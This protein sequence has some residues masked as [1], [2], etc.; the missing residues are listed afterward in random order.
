MKSFI[1]S[2]ESVVTEAVEGL[3]STVPHLGRLDG[4]PAIKVC[5]DL[6]HDGNKTVSVIS[7]GGSGHEPAFAGYVG[8]GMLAAAVIGDVFASPSE[9]AV[10][11]AIRQVTGSAGC[12]LIL[13]NY[14]GDRLNFGA[15]A[16]RAKAEGLNVEMV[17]VGDDCALPD[18]PAVGRRGLAG[19]LFALKAAGAAAAAGKDLAAVRAVAERA[20]TSVGTMGCALTTCTLPGQMTSTRLGP[21]EMEMGLGLHGEPGAYAARVRPIDG[22]I[23]ELIDRIAGESEGTTYLHVNPGEKV[24][25]LIN[26]LGGA[27]VLEMGVIA[28]A[29]VHAVL[30]QLHAKLERVYVGALMTSLDM[31]GVS[32][33]ILK[34][35]PEGD[36]ELINGLD[37]PTE[38]VAWPKHGG[39]YIENKIPA[40]LPCGT[41][42]TIAFTAAGDATKPQSGIEKGE[43]LLLNADLVRKCI[44]AACEAVLRLEGE[45]NDLDGK[46][47][48][49]DCG[50]TMATGAR[51]VNAALSEMALDDPGGTA[52][53]LAQAVGGSIGGT[54]GAILK[55]FFSAAGAALRNFKI[56]E[57]SEIKSPISRVDA[58][59]V[60]L[61]AGVE[62]IKKYG[63]ASKGDRT[64]ID[65]LEPAAD[66]LE[67]AAKDGATGPVAA[68]AA[69]RAAEQ[70][71]E[72][73]KT[74][75][76]AAGRSSY[77]PVAALEGVPDPGAVGVAAWFTEVAVALAE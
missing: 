55:I 69:A 8:A 21:D 73:T 49:G 39:K 24:A 31:R 32:L 5:Y 35:G 51:A 74:M 70:G 19:S 26:N 56:S 48:D 66:A 59:A 27:T 58:V 33:S 53:G 40:P 38:A 15:A 28:R 23:T 3:I 50:T 13:I 44:Q 47:G 46:V 11:A 52:L 72:A 16:E 14:T 71:V 20:A 42:D 37:A 68:A 25:L 7:G 63:G 30:S 67:K 29:A 10:L 9:E 43:Q 4:F 62:A 17:I 54:S 76:A 75:K 57:E 65:A 45:L 2:P 77:V 22:I 18:K 12:L 36:E 6:G 60:G 61:R 64:M 41:T 34:L 1:N